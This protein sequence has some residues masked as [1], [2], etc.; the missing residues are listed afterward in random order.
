MRT[1]VCALA[2]AATLVTSTAWQPADVQAVPDKA[3]HLQVVNARDFAQPLQVSTELSVRY[4]G[5][6]IVKL[7]LWVGNVRFA[8]KSLDPPQERG[9]ASFMLDPAYL[10]AGKHT[11]TLKA[12]EADGTVG[13][14]RLNASVEAP[15]LSHLPLAIVA[16]SNGSV[17]SGKVEI[18]L[19][20]SEQLGRPYV[21]LFINRQFKTLRNFPPY[22]YIWDTT[23]VEN[24]WHLIEA[25]GV[26]EARNT[27]R[28]APVRVLVNN[29]GGQTHREAPLP[30]ARLT[31]P[32]MPLPPASIPS[33]V[34]PLPVMPE[35]ILRDSVPVVTPSEV[36]VSQ[37]EKP[38]V[39][40]VAR[41]AVPPAPRT[42]RTPR[43]TEPPRLSV[44]VPTADQAESQPNVLAELPPAL[45]AGQKLAIPQRMAMASTPPTT[46]EVKQGDTLS[47]IA[48]RHGVPIKVLA[49]A[50]GISNPNRVRAGEKLHIPSS[51]FQVVF[52]NTR[53]VFDVPPRVQNGI[54][55]AP[56]RQ[57][58]EHVGGL[59]YWYPQSRTVRAINAEREIEMRIGESEARVNN[60]NV[61]MEVAPFIDR[62]RTIV[63]LSF[64]R[65][66][67]NVRIQY[68]PVTGNLLIESER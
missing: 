28:A 24:G 39:Q 21:S 4:Q 55:L 6:A 30:E 34:E 49:E 16:P 33:T 14:T 65:D 51:T 13:I 22:T 18:N 46:Y 31:V 64:V 2:L 10:S 41:A 27:Y 56:F 12:I 11:I 23:T 15:T 67:L 26:D 58:F 50:N 60:Q 38:P 52:D 3:P 54:P 19:R 36:P 45:M 61:T 42:N 5:K 9:V 53:I 47:G 57:I 63:P 7:E 8:E 32:D 48:R 25:L 1:S 68:D 59:L 66:A 20:V 35:P 29:P 43:I 62:G 44:L 40:Q 37:P 17:V